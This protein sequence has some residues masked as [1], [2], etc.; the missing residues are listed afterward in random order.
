MPL[1]LARSVEGAL[2]DPPEAAFQ[3]TLAAGSRSEP[4]L[5]VLLAVLQGLVVPSAASCSS[6]FAT[7]RVPS[8]ALFRD[9][10]VCLRPWAGDVLVSRQAALPAAVPG[11]GAV[12]GRE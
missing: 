8:R 11:P 6:P 1:L 3:L 2:P 4:A 7:L 12:P 9:S 5:I 10:E